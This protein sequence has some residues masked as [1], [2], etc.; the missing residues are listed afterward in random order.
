[1]S[2]R[3][4]L[5]PAELVVRL[6]VPLSLACFPLVQWTSQRMKLVP[7]S[8]VVPHP[9]FFRGRFQLSCWRR[10]LLELLALG[11]EDVVVRHYLEVGTSLPTFLQNPFWITSA[12]LPPVHKTSGASSRIQPLG[13]SLPGELVRRD[14]ARGQRR[15]SKELAAPRVA[16]PHQHPVLRINLPRIRRGSMLD[17]LGHPLDRVWEVRPADG[18]H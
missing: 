11:V 18:P 12:A 4:N 7:V 1:M 8:L 2:Q 6:L 10:R 16:M 17:V 15:W 3:M 13:D 9:R 14:R 5:A